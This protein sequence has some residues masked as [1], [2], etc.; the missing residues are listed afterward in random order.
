MSRRL[1][2]RPSG[3]Q[4]GDGSPHRSGIEYR[5]FFERF[6]GSCRTKHIRREPDLVELIKDCLKPSRRPP[7]DPRKGARYGVP[8]RSELEPGFMRMEPW[9]IEYLFALAARARRGILE[10]GR[11][12]G[13]STFCMA[14][15]NAGVPIRSIDIAPVNDERLAA[16]FEEVGVGDNVELVVG[17]SQHGDYPGVE[18]LDLLFIDGDHSYAGC[19]ADLD[20]WYPRVVPG[21]HVVLHDCYFGSDVREAVIDFIDVHAV[22]VIQQPYISASHWRTPA[23]SLAH[24]RRPVRA[25][26]GPELP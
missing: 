2:S 1:Q 14:C 26:S 9:E 25:A 23:G 21:G 3:A 8:A 15:A 10:T 7:I 17:D 5:E 16:L 24:F 4:A 19:T 18:E 20:Q 22:D 13:G 11:A 12:H 6:M